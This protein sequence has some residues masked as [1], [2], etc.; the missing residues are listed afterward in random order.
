M[1]YKLHEITITRR[2][3]TNIYNNKLKTVKMEVNVF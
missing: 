1:L 3:Y 2:I